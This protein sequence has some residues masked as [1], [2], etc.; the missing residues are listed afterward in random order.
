MQAFDNSGNLIEVELTGERVIYRDGKPINYRELSPGEKNAA[1]RVADDVYD[2]PKYVGGFVQARYGG[3]T[4]VIP[5]RLASGFENSGGHIFGDE[6]WD[7]VVE[8]MDGEIRERLHMELSPCS[9]Q[10]F[11]DA[12]AAAHSEKFGEQWEL[13]K[14]NPVW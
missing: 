12:Y 2:L 11:F 3:F 4:A 6:E 8:M 10:E 7:S 9:I 14:A 1:D 5:A 13:D